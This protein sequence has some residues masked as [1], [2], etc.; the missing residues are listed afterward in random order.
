MNEVSIQFGEPLQEGIFLERTNR[1]IVRCRLSNFYSAGEV[2]EAHLPDPGRLKELLIP[3][4]RIWLRSANNPNRK[5]RWS[6]VLVE[7]PNGKDFV[8]LDTTL[9]NRL[10]QKALESGYM[11]EFYRWKFQRTEYTLGDSRWDFLLQNAEGRDMLLEVK[12]VTLKKD[13]IGLFPD[14]V[15]ARGV[16]HVRELTKFAIQGE[17]ETALLF[18]AQREDIDII[19][20]ATD[21]DEVFALELHK[22]SRA[23]VHILGRK[24]HVSLQG[25]SLGDPVKVVSKKLKA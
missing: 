25:I 15:T 1:F 17:V 22:A 10:I 3:G 18:V 13:G 21:I 2:V 4:C 8:S 6:A 16:K 24:C 14:A 19:K 12:S 5:T 7:D 11:E 9:P 20:A 23:G